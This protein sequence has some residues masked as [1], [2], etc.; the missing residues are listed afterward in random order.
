LVSYFYCC[1]GIEEP[2]AII[3]PSSTIPITGETNIARLFGRI[4]GVYD[5]GAN[6]YTF[7]TRCDMCLDA[8][9]AIYASSSSEKYCKVCYLV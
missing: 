9:D 1:T 3:D 8:C 2:V 5:C 7:S 6:T 4:L